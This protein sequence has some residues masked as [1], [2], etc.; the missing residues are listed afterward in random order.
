MFSVDVSVTPSGPPPKLHLCAMPESGLRHLNIPF[1]SSTLTFLSL[2]PSM[3]YK[4]WN[5]FNLTSFD[6]C[7][8]FT[9]HGSH[10]WLN[11][12]V[13]WLIYLFNLSFIF[14][15]IETQDPLMRFHILNEQRNRAQLLLE[16]TRN[17]PKRAWATIFHQKI[18]MSHKQLRVERGWH[19]NW[20]LCRM[21]RMMM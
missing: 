16:C 15:S 9:K 11:Q 3:L 4:R 10:L 8:Y 5:L 20:T 14:P 6:C 2:L 13:I 18:A 1:S 12:G 7:Y 19:L 17:W 21:M